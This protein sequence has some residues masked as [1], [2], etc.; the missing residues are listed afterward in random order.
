MKKDFSQKLKELSVEA[1]QNSLPALSKF[2]DSLSDIAKS[3]TLILEAHN[4]LKRFVT[5]IEAPVI[6]G[7]EISKDGM[8]R[9]KLWRIWDDSKL[10][11]MFIMLNPSVADEKKDDAT[12]RRCMAFAKL[13]GYG[14]IL[15]G[16]LYAYRATDPKELKTAKEPVGIL[17]AFSLTQMVAN[18]SLL[19][20]AW[21]DFEKHIKGTHTIPIHQNT[22]A[23]GLNKSGTPKH[24][25]YVAA[26][27]ELINFPD[28]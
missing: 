22:K 6:M 14:G 3:P 21:G 13:W 7:A 25:L 8:Y 10:K 27:T 2:L 16:N 1:G 26:N 23:L 4:V 18:C 15:V 11:V 9:Y 19:V 12:I 17:N 5:P 20:C 24:P 28:I